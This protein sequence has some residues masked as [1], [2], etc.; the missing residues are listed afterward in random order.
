LLSEGNHPTDGHDYLFLAINDIINKSNSFSRRLNESSQQKERETSTMLQELHPKFILRGSS[1]A[2]AVRALNLYSITDLA[3]QMESSWCAEKSLYDLERLTTDVCEEMRFL[4]ERPTILN[5]STFLREKFQFRDDA[6]PSISEVDLVQTA[7][8]SSEGDYFVHIQ[9]VRLFEDVRRG[10]K[11]L[12]LHRRN[13]SILRAMGVNFYQTDYD[14]LR[15]ILEG[16]RSSVT[17]LS[18]DVLANC[19][20]FDEAVSKI[21][22]LPSSENPVVSACSILK[23]LGFPLMKDAQA[24]FILSLELTQLFEFACFL[25]HQLASEAYLFSNLPLCMTDPLSKESCDHIISGFTRFYEANCLQEAIKSLDDFVKNVL[26][27]YEAQICEASTSHQSLRVFLQDNNFC[28]ENSFPFFALLPEEISIGNYIPL[29]QQLHQ[30][31]L[32]SLWKQGRDGAGGTGTEMTS[33]GSDINPSFTKPTRGRCWL[34]TETQE[35]ERDICGEDVELDP[36]SSLD[37][38]NYEGLWF[39]I[40]EVMKTEAEERSNSNV[41]GNIEKDEN[42]HVHPFSTHIVRTELRRSHSF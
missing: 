36:Q 41:A 19:L 30:I 28:D 10:L 9:D 14:Y 22:N 1:G 32:A 40:E 2:V 33:K 3:S 38:S 37:T 18:N 26:S 27:F 16:L 39:E 12:C 29:R 13:S 25:G 6:L 17:L 31:K 7:V 5:P 4:S 24:N 34:W 35:S 11:K 21:V 15:S 23:I 42:R 8:V 20:T